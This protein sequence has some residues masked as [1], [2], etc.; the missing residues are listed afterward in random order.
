MDVNKLK[1]TDQNYLQVYAVNTVH[2]YKDI[3]SATFFKFYHVAESC[4]QT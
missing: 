2:V 1:F 4:A 3:M